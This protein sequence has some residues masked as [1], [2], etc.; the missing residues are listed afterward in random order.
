M[1]KSIL[2]ILE[3]NVSAGNLYDVDYVSEIGCFHHFIERLF[4]FLFFFLS[5]TKCKTVT[6][7]PSVSV[8][9]THPPPADMV[10]SLLCLLF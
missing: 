7:P 5:F 9:K 2:A 1:I 6:I 10:E 4:F 3:S 8:Q